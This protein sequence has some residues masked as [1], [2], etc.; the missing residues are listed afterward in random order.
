MTAA[1]LDHDWDLALMLLQWHPSP[2]A[3]T[4]KSLSRASAALRTSSCFLQT[5]IP[6]WACEALIL[7]QIIACCCGTEDHGAAQPLGKHLQLSWR[8]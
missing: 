2:D 8:I 3:I 6:S 5:V 4:F 7:N 1:L